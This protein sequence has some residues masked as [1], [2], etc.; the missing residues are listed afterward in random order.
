MGEDYALMDANVRTR[1]DWL[2]YHDLVL[3]VDAAMAYLR[4][5]GVM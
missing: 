2:W 3:D 5:Q 4:S 1:Y